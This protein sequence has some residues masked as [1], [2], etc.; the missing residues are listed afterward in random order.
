MFAAK[1]FEFTSESLSLVVQP[2]A[3]AIYYKNENVIKLLEKHGAK[4]PVS[5][6]I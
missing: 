3:D 1:G 5:L 4:R 6:Q 2:L